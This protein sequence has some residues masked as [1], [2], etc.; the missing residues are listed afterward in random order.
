MKTI[1]R[2]AL[3]LLLAVHVGV[4]AQT[5]NPKTEA[6]AGARRAAVCFACHNTKGI[7]EIPGV[8]NLAGQK[9]DY[10][11][12]ALKAYRDGHTRQNDIMNAMAAPLS[13]GDIVNISAYFSLQSR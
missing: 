9:R 8:P 1:H 5:Q 12:N 3:L 11:E 2:P 10:L 7:A 6:A 4:H 13:D